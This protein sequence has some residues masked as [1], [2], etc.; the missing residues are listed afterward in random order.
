MGYAWL[1]ELSVFFYTYN[2]PTK[3]HSDAVHLTWWMMTTELNE[4]IQKMPIYI[5]NIS[6]D[7]IKILNKFWCYFFYPDWHTN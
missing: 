3:L 7:K 6:N 2:L 1:V 5:E 4:V